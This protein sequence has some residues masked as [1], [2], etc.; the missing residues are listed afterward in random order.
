MGREDKEIS[1]AR[2]CLSMG[3]DI[4]VI[5]KI[6]ELP[7]ERIIALKSTM[8]TGQASHTTH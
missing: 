5:A 4:D 8:Q 3:M 7:V 6:T 1:V 2:N